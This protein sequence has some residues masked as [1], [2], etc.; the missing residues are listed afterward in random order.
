MSIEKLAQMRAYMLYSAVLD[1]V[2]YQ[3]RKK[4]LFKFSSLTK[5]LLLKVV[6]F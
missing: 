4:K 1:S 5:R 3:E 6:S 2:F